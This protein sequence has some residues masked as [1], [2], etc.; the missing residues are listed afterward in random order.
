LQATF[1]GAPSAPLPSAGDRGLSI[2]RDRVRNDSN[3]YVR[4][5]SASVLSQLTSL[6]DVRP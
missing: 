2:L 4:Q 5:H 1:A 6:D 3:S